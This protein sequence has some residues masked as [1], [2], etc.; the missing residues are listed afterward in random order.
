MEYW[1]SGTDRGKQNIEYWWS[2]TDRRKQNI[3]YWWNGTD[4]GKQKYLGVKTCISA[5]LSITYLERNGQ[6]SN[7]GLCSDRPATKSAATLTKLYV[8]ISMYIYR[9]CLY[10]AVNTLS[11]GYTNQSVNVV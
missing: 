2:G 1:W 5:S 9:H 8:Y 10:R 4:R 6:G 11:L 3:E 7:P